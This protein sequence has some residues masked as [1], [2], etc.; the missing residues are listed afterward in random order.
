MTT[1]AVNT[2]RVLVGGDV[3]TFAVIANDAI[4]QGA[5]AGL[6]AASGHARPLTPADKFVGFAIAL[7]DN[8]GGAAAAIN[9]DVYRKGT[10]KLTVAGVVI[11]DVGQ[12]V[13]ATDDNAFSFVPTGGVFI[14][15]VR[16]YVSAGVAEVDFDVTNFVDPYAGKIRE[17]LGAATLT[18]DTQDSGKYIFCT[19]D[20][21]VTICATAVALRDVTLVNMGPF[22]TVQVT[23]DPDNADKMHGPNTTGA[24][25]AAIVNTKATARRGDYLTFDLGHADGPVITSI[26]GT[27]AQA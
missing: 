19:V 16:R 13:Y 21:V 12:P 8:T 22:G 6:V 15:F 27:W 11:T 3:N 10:V 20:T 14:G 5:A 26:N 9:V 23:A 24:D 25:G 17:T 2:P 7:A 4:Y 18:L 1:L